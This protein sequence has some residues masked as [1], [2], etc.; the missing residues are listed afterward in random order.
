MGWT[1]S[2][3]RKELFGAR[4]RFIIAQEPVEPEDVD[5]KFA[6]EP[7]TT[8]P[9]AAFG[10]FMFDTEHDEEGED[11]EVIYWSVGAFLV[12]IPLNDRYN[13]Q[14]R[15]PGFNARPTDGSR[16]GNTRVDEAI[17]HEVQNEE[18]CSHLSKR[19]RTWSFVKAH[20]IW[21]TYSKRFC[22]GVL[23]TSRVWRSIDNE[24]HI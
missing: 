2:K 24:S 6:P 19:Y 18:S 22:D 14:L 16:K 1:P 20:L 15:G 17:R 3:K 11:E 5:Q 8:A 4:S 23:Q 9:I 21:T 13:P 10:M 7:Q 12:P